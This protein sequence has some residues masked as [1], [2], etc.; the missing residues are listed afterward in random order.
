MLK[1]YLR[2]F[3]LLLTLGVV[4]V[5]GFSLYFSSWLQ[6]PVSDRDIIFVVDKGD[7]FSA[8]TSRLV[9][10]GLIHQPFLFKVYGRLTG[11]DTGLVAGEYSISPGTTVASLVEHL[12]SGDVIQYSVTL[13]EGQTLSENLSGWKAS[14]LELVLDSVDDERLKSILQIDALSSEGL[15]FSDTYFYEAGDTDISILRRAHRRLMNVLQEEWEGRQKGLPYKT[16]YDALVLA[17]IVERETAVSKERPV[18]AG[19]FVRRLQ[20]GMRLQSDP[21]VIYG[22]GE[23][24]QGKIRRRDLNARTPYNTYRINGLPP[25]PIAS[26]GREAIRAVLNPAEG[27]ALYFVARGDG[28]HKFSNSLAEHNRAV[29]KYQ[30]NRRENYRSTPVAAQSPETN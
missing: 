26:V 27:S 12:S 25:T 10:E 6:R 13:V 9:S 14:R 20:K 11:Q 24:Y 28:S 30:L 4:F 1:G 5:G 3:S 8:V 21:T 19:V 17:S 18:I 7:S 23:D 22:M 16:P 29:R 15:F 2:V